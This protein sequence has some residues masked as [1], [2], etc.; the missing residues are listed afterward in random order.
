MPKNTKSATHKIDREKTDL[1]KVLV[2]II[3]FLSLFGVL[4]SVSR[5]HIGIHNVDG[6]QNLRY[7]NSFSESELIDIGSD[8]KIR[9]GTIL[10]LYGLEQITESFKMLF[11][12]SLCFGFSLY[13]LIRRYL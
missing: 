7:L 2:L 5:F 8:G 3:F 6:G 1:I 10:Y 12:F 9:T 4:E 11:F 13:D